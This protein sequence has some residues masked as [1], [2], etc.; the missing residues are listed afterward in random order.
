MRLMWPQ[1]AQLAKDAAGRAVFCLVYCAEAHARDEWPV[2]DALQGVKTFDQARSLAERLAA[3]RTFV[4]DFA[5]TGIAVADAIDDGFTKA[6][7]AWPLRLF[8]FHRGKVA[9]KAEPTPGYGY[10]LNDVRIALDRAVPPT[11]GQEA[12]AD[13]AVPIDVSHGGTR[14]MLCADQMCA[15]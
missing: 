2:G 9:F 15:E 12:L 5:W 7:G 8:V 1:V 10:E 13:M 4:A 6:L 14:V 11:S 3:L